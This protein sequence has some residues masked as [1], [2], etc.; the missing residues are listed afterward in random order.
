MYELQYADY[1][2][3]KVHKEVFAY[4]NQLQ[5]HFRV[6]YCYLHVSQPV[7]T[8]PRTTT[9]HT[10]AA[11][12]SSQ[13]THLSSEAALGAVRGADWKRLAGVR[14]SLFPYRFC[15][16][17]TAQ[18]SL[19]VDLASKQAFVF[20]SITILLCPDLCPLAMHLV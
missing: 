2:T 14:F 17:S 3:S 4:Y 6:W 1:C 16:P 8:G 9:V 7:V 13:C 12:G 15:L 19:C 20:T 18:A 5:T 11:R 10:C